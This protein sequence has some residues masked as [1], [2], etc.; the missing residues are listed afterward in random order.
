MLVGY[1]ALNLV[2]GHHWV[3]VPSLIE[4]YQEHLAEGDDDLAFIDFLV[5]HYADA[6]HSDSDGS[7]EDLPFKHD[8]KEHIG[9]DH[10]YWSPV[11]SAHHL[12]LP[13]EGA[14]MLPDA[15]GPMD[16]FR[17]ACLQPPRYA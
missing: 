10:V 8:H 15:D 17:R 2:C 7:H 9:V 3:H 6:E 14:S 12:F 13:I 16:G 1:M 4:H 11:L 5:L